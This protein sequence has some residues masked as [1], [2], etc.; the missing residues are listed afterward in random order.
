MHYLCLR[1][2]AAH[3]AL[4]VEEHLAL[5]VARQ[6]ARQ[7]VRLLAAQSSAQPGTT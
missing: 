7:P 1:Q 2:P 6:L 4:H 3:L 5:H